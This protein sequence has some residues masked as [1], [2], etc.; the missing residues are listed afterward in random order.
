MHFLSSVTDFSASIGAWVFKLCI[1]LEG[2][3]VCRVKENQIAHV[4][5]AFFFQIFNFS[6]S[7]SYVMHMEIFDLGFSNLVERLGMTRCTV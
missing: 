7:H 6:I 2:G 4:Y 3:Q 5:F 1:H